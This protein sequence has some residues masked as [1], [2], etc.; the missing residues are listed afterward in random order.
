LWVVTSPPWSP[1]DAPQLCVASPR[2]G[3]P[4]T[5]VSGQLGHRDAAITLRVYAH[6]LPVGGRDKLVDLLDAARPNASQ[7]HP[8]ALDEVDQKTLSALSEMV[9]RV[10]IEPTTR[11][12]RVPSGKRKR[13]K[14]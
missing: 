6:W 2:A 13:S 11:R 14:F 1:P 7:A 8:A 4:I 10:G 5:Y 3:A 9:S 12:L